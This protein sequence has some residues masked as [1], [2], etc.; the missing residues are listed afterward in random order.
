MDE[1]MYTAGFIVRLRLP[2]R[3]SPEDAKREL[4]TSIAFGHPEVSRPW[5]IPEPRGS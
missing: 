5:V 3:I 1:K 4:E 2:E